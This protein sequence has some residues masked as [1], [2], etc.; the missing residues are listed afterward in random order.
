MKMDNYIKKISNDFW[1]VLENNKRKIRHL[2]GTDVIIDQMAMLT[3]IYMPAMIQHQKVFPQ[4]KGINKGKTVVVIGTGPTFDYYM[5]IPDAVH[6]G[7]NNAVFRKDIMFDYI[8]MADFD[9]G[10]EFFEKVY[11]DSQG[12]VRFFGIHYTRKGALIPAY[13]REWEDVETFYIDDYNGD[14]YGN[15][16]EKSRKFVYPLD[17][18]ISPIKAY[19]T[20]MYCAFQFALWTHPD[21]I[22]IVG[23]DCSGKVNAHASGLN[24]ESVNYGNTNFDYNKFNYRRFI[25]PWRKLKDF[26]ENYYPDIEIISLNPVGLK[27]IFKDKY[28]DKYRKC[29]KN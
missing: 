13:I 18:S 28:T 4:Y 20:V 24:Y 17:L 1:D 12:S 16:Y 6:I 9:N 21:K 2:L 19:G 15:I 23:A 26:A 7:I 27:G 22:Y 29:D 5:P 11:A 14:I 3:D 10:R 8:F 25:R